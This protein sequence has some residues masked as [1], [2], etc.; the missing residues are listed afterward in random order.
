MNKNLE[1]A[2]KLTVIC[3]V[4]V[5]LLTGINLLTYKKIAENEIKAEEAANKEI[6]SEGE[7]FNKENFLKT[8][9]DN[10]K[11]YYF[12]VLDQGGN[13]LGYNVSS[14][15]SGYGGEMKVMIAFDKNLKIL[16][17]KLLKNNETPGLGK[18][19]EAPEYMEKFKDSNSVDY[20][21]PAKKN[22]LKA[23]FQDSVTGATITFN[24]I[25]Q[26]A[27]YAIKLLEKELKG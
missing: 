9:V 27:D 26:A 21:F 23:E 19:A 18:K 25:A 7:K 24:G 13:L 1:I 14:I 11:I 12:K 6:F 17:M 2:L 22:L 20:P 16:N 10:N 4:S 15:G 5:V 8:Q 3:F